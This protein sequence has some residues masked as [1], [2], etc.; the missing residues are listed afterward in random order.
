MLRGR[1]EE[2]AVLDDLLGG[3]RAGRSGT[4]VVCGEEDV[5]T[6]VADSE[7]IQ[8]A[9]AGAKLKVIPKAGHL[10]NMENFEAVTGA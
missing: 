1:R 5:I 9:V 3:A 4:L 10:S 7:A 6:P 2:C 8:K